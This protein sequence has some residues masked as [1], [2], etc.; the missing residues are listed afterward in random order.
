MSSANASPKEI[1]IRVRKS[2]EI[3]DT[4]R[5]NKEEKTKVIKGFKRLDLEKGTEV[6]YQQNNKDN[7]LV[8]DFTNNDN[9]TNNQLLTQKNQDDNHIRVFTFYN[10]DIMSETLKSSDTENK[11]SMT[12]VNEDNPMNILNQINNEL[13]ELSASLQKFILPN[14]TDPYNTTHPNASYTAFTFPHQYNDY[15]YSN[16]IKQKAN[17][18]QLYHSTSSSSQTTYYNDY[19]Y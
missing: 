2:K 7:Q 16:S 17:S 1:P 4:Q 5:K 3:Q 12:G 13:N 6:E 8:K 19:K 9:N 14:N 15:D 11:K 10:Q 18:S